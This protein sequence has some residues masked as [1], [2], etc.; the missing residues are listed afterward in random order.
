M[1]TILCAAHITTKMNDIDK[2]T[3]RRTKPRGAFFGVKFSWSVVGP[4]VGN[5]KAFIILHES[6]PTSTFF[7][8]SIEFVSFVH[9]KFAPCP[10]M[11][12]EWTY[13]TSN[14]VY[15]FL[16]SYSWSIWQLSLKCPT[17]RFWLMLLFILTFSLKQEPL[18]SLEAIKCFDSILVI[19]KFALIT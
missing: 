10:Y 3:G 8:V 9:D 14:L 18:S 2:K 19:S 12:K 16:V 11:T 6:F 17:N 13:D 7:H 4:A 15:S 5:G 1:L